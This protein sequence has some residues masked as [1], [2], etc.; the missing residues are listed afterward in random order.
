MTHL[1]R[2]CGIIILLFRSAYMCYLKV[3]DLSRSQLSEEAL[4]CLRISTIATAYHNLISCSY[5]RKFIFIHGGGQRKWR[6]MG[7]GLNISLFIII[8]LSPFSQSDITAR[9][10][11]HMHKNSAHGHS[12][13][14]VRSHP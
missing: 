1:L 12:V 5:N 7:K 2:T 4:I 10:S 3:K 13:T 6:L 11:H 9:S 14:A 8:N